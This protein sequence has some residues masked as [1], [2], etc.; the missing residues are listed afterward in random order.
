MSK[1]TDLPTS[2][3]QQLLDGIEVRLLNQ[4]EWPRVQQLLDEHHYLGAFKP[5]GERLHYTVTDA[6]GDWLGVLV[7]CA[8]ARRLRARDQWIGW[9]EE[10][11][12]RRLA[13]IVNNTRFLLLPHKT[14]PNLASKTLRRVLARL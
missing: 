12:R 11:R 14:V 5:V 7:F 6:Q 8:A 9:S 3:Q 2:P 13:L 1:C 10:Q 4:D